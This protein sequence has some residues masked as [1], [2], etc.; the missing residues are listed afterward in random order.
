MLTE[1]SFNGMLFSPLAVY[2]PIALVLTVVVRRLLH[3]A[4]MHFQ[5]WKKEA[6][7]NEAWFD[8]SLFIVFLALTI[9]ITGKV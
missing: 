7:W 2:I 4:N 6:L 3:F 9:A 8:I 5:L 1:I